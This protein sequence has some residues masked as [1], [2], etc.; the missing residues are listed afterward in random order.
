MLRVSLQ[1]GAIRVEREL[2]MSLPEQRQCQVQA[3]TLE[4]RVV[5]NRAPEAIGCLT[6]ISST[7]EQCAEIVL[8]GR[9]RFRAPMQF[10]KVCSA[11][12]VRPSK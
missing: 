8:T 3:A 7:P 6:N 10:R 1:H 11:S 12:D 4:R 9:V 2:E 5:A